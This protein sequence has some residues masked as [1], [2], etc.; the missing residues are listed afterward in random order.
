M[1]RQPDRQDVCVWRSSRR[2]WHATR[3]NKAFLTHICFIICSTKYEGNEEQAGHNNIF[4]SKI[5]LGTHKWHRRAGGVA[6]D[7]I[8]QALIKL[9][10]MPSMQRVATFVMIETA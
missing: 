3:M 7:C 1:D 5:V 9:F 6:C 8:V 4:A 10:N 2:S